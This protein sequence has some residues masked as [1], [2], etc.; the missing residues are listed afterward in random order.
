VLDLYSIY[1]GGTS[2][3]EIHI[4]NGATSF[5]TFSF[6]GVSGLG[7]VADNVAW[8]FQLIR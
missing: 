5:G 3:T 4:L 6:Q 7:R 1:R 2:G 8:E